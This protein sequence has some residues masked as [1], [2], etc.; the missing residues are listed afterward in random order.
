LDRVRRLFDAVVKQLG[1]VNRA[2]PQTGPHLVVLTEPKD[3]ELIV[4]SPTQ[5]VFFGLLGGASV[6]LGLTWL[7]TRAVAVRSRS[8]TA[9]SRQVPVLVELPVLI[10]RAE[11]VSDRSVPADWVVYHRPQSAIA[12]QYRALRSLVQFRMTETV[13]HRIGIVSETDEAPALKI[14]AN[15]AAS[16]ALSGKKTLLIDCTTHSSANI[17]AAGAAPA[18]LSDVFAERAEP[19]DALVRTPIPNLDVAVGGPLSVDKPTDASYATGELLQE[20]Y[21][22]TVVALPANSDSQ[23]STAVGL[24]DALVFA[25]SPGGDWDKYSRQVERTATL[26]G[27]AILGAVVCGTTLGER[28]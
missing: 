22:L 9:G 4:R 20:K 27:C 19:T 15:L 8:Q 2:K 23:F 14:A 26:Y 16:F 18:S 13:R 6:G 21:E 28:R 3:G 5:A 7:K 17:A 12:E 24:V 11:P 1:D 10:S 25:T